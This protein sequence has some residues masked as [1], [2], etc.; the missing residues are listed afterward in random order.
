MMIN[1]RKSKRGN[2]HKHI[3]K[4]NYTTP[5]CKVLKKVLNPLIQQGVVKVAVLKQKYKVFIKKC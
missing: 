3:P 5:I 1:P 2:A 4:N